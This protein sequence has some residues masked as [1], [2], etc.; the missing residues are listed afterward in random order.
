MSKK[1][2][3]VLVAMSACLAFG[4]SDDDSSD[5]ACTTG[6]KKCEA[7]IPSVCVNGVW[8]AGTKCENGCDATTNTCK[9]KDPETGDCKNAGEKRCSDNQ[10]QVCTNGQW[11]KDTDCAN[12]C[13]AATKACKDGGSDIPDTC[14]KGSSKGL[15][16]KD[17]MPYICGDTGYYVGKCESGTCFECPDGYWVACG[18]D[19]ATACDGHIPAPL[20]SNIPSTCTKGTDKGLCGEDGMPYICGNNGYYKGKCES[21]T[22]FECPDGKWVACGADKATACAGHM[23]PDGETTSCTGEKVTTGGEEGACCDSSTYQVSCVNDGANALICSKGAVKKWTCKDNVCSVADNRVTCENP[24]GGSSSGG[25]TTS[26]T[27]ETVSVDGVVG[28]CCDKAKYAPDCAKMLRCDSNG[29]IKA[30]TCKEGTSC[31][32]H[33]DGKCDKDSYCSDGTYDTTKYPLGYF[34]CV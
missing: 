14:T 27:G 18:A 7:G 30:I 24:N 6:A 10:L 26:C 3:A 34:Q 21:G 4:C 11:T 29:V 5:D 16:G 25:S 20:P 1:L 12:G 2:L 23:P 17:G 9:A 31:T 22:C 8:K 19:L 32:L 33:T 28:Q 13:D 15:C